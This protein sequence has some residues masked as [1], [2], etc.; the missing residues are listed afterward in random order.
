MPACMPRACLQIEGDQKHGKMSPL[1]RLGTK[2]GTEVRG[3][4]GHSC[5]QLASLSLQAGRGVALLPT[6]QLR[7]C[8]LDHIIPHKPRAG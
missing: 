1:V 7:N 8:C 3:W 5:Q 2:K 6:F 4:G